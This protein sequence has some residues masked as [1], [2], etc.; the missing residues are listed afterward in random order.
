LEQIELEGW[1]DQPGANQAMRFGT[2]PSWAHQLAALLPPGC[3][4]PEVRHHCRGGHSA[5]L[6]SSTCR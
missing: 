3:L 5:D 2:L 4:P 1:F 6:A